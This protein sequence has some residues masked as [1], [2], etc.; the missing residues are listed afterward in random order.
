MN[1]LKKVMC[2]GAIVFRVVEGAVQFLLIKPSQGK[3]DGE[4]GVP[5]GHSE[6]GEQREQCAIR[7]T[8]EETGIVPRLIFELPPVF[9]RNDKEMKTVH[10]WLAKQLNDGAVPRPQQE[11]V[12]SC[13]WWPVDNLPPV[14]AYQQ[15]AIKAAVE[16]INRNMP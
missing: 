13:K 9:T 4:W 10:L 7:E 3:P 16:A 11:E 14:H 6:E 12:S 5:K 8:Y 15:P 1:K 2:A